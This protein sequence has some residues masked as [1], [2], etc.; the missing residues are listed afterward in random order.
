MVLS[1]FDLFETDAESLGAAKL[2]QQSLEDA[3]ELLV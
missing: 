1:S 2:T 3:R